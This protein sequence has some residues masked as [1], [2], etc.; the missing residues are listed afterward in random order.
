M[1]HKWL[2]IL[3][4]LLTAATS[5]AQDFVCTLPVSRDPTSVITQSFIVSAPPTPSAVL[6][7]LPGGAGIIKLTPTTPNSSPICTAST[8]S[9]DG[10]LEINSSNF[11]VRSR[12]L[13]A[14]HGFY[15]I[16]LNAATDFLST[17]NGLTDEQGS[18]N[19]ISDVLDIIS[20]ARTTVPDVPVLIVGT[21]RGTGG[22]FVAGLNSSPAGP[23]G[24]VFTDPINNTTD[25]DSLL[26]AKL[27]AISVPVLLMDDAGNTCTGTLNSGNVAVKKALTSSPEVS[28]E[29]VPAGGLI[30]LTDSCKELSDHGF[31]GV[32]DKAV[33]KIVAWIASAGL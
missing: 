13:F 6:I 7:L 18:A 10:T 24:L 31:F 32:E 25:P 33:A 11:L 15:T 29:Q 19:H 17:T 5:F 9:T 1:W 22:A 28:R 16:S 23:D 20:W 27:S 8:P 12:W 14:G 2:L 4:L 21:S 3:A 26:N 30:P